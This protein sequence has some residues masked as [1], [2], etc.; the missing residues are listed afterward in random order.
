MPIGDLLAEISGGQ[1]SPAPSP[2]PSS[3]LGIKRKADDDSNGATSTKLTKARQPD[4]SYSTSKITRDA[5]GQVVERSYSASRP[6]KAALPSRSS[7]STNL[8]SLPHRTSSPSTTN[9]RYEP[10]A[11]NTQ[12]SAPTTNGKPSA[13]PSKVMSSAKLSSDASSRARVTTPISSATRAYPAKPSP[14]T[15]TASD[16]SKAPKKGSFK[17][18]MARASRAQETMGK[19]GTIQHRAIEKPVVKK[20]RVVSKVDSKAGPTPNA[21]DRVGRPYTGSS[22]PPMKPGRDSGR[23]G[24]DGPRSGSAKE[25][26]SSGKSKPTPNDPPEKKIKK[27]AVATTGYSGTARP[28]P[29]ATRSKGPSTKSSSRPA[30]GGL[31]APPRLGRRS[32]YDDD[33]YD[34][35]LDDFVDYDDEEEDDGPRY[36]YASDES[37]D[38]EAGMSDID[39]EE[40]RAEFAAREEDRREQALEEKLKREKE[41]RKRRW[42]Q[43]NR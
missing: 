9:G 18:I 15:P 35:D 24:N 22:R 10:P 14:T 37:S 13:Q 19:V 32:R 33:E 23:P 7:S 26:K 2:K 36:N 30:S 12:R 28:R 39:S 6:V 38:M 21:K 25:V 1:P 16:S 3:S 20:E 11:S 8:S 17:E 27:S 42:A 31:L 41:E 40:R 43:G 29:G 5:Q 34:E 4:G